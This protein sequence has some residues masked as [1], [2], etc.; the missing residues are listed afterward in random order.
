MT[1]SYGTAYPDPWWV[2]NSASLRKVSEAW[3]RAHG[4]VTPVGA[5]APVRY[6]RAYKEVKND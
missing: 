1:R 2:A 5:C 3:Q 4:S 6:T